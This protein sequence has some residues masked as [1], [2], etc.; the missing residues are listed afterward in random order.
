[1]AKRKVPMDSMKEHFLPLRGRCILSSRRAVTLAMLLRVTLV[2]LL[3]L[4]LPP[5]LLLL[6]QLERMER[7]PLLR[8]EELLQLVSTLPHLPM[9]L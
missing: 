4:P 9:A 3:L 8:W 5:R 1:M 7:H 6:L 2:L